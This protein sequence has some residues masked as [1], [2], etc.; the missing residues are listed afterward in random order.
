[1]RRVTLSCCLTQLT[2]QY[3]Q[4]LA[5]IDSVE[6]GPELPWLIGPETQLFSNQGDRGPSRG[7]LLVRLWLPKTENLVPLLY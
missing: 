6:S 5:R 4:S 7:L 1:M 2:I 3:N